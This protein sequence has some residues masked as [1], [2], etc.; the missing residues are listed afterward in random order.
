MSPP[1]EEGG[2]LPREGPAPTTASSSI[3]RVAAAKQPGRGHR[4]AA[5]P[6]SPSVPAA[7]PVVHGVLHP[8]A[9]RRRLA[10]IVVAHCQLCG[11]AHVHRAHP[12]PATRFTR[13]PSCRPS[14]E[15]EIVV[16]HGVV[17]GSH[18]GRLVTRPSGPSPRENGRTAP[19]PRIGRSEREKAIS[20]P[21]RDGLVVRAP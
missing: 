20:G 16:Q 19:S 8:P 6:A 11:G 1:N 14:A 21:A 7:R 3:A 12:A 18:R 17:G 9:G 15:Y 5:R 2:P 4:T 10:L 13:A